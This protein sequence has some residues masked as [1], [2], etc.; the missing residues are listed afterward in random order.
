MD[1]LV[2]LVRS[3]FLFVFS[4]RADGYQYGSQQLCHSRMECLSIQRRSKGYYQYYQCREKMSQ[5]KNCKSCVW[6][7]E[8]LKVTCPKYCNNYPQDADRKQC[9]ES[10]RKTEGCYSSYCFNKCPKACPDYC[11]VKNE[12]T[13]ESCESS[14]RSSFTKCRDKVCIS[15][16]CSKLPSTNSVMKKLRNF[17]SL[18]PTASKSSLLSTTSKPPVAQVDQSKTISKSVI[19]PPSV[20]PTLSSSK[21]ESKSTQEASA[22]PRK[23]QS[24]RVSMSYRVFPFSRLW[25]G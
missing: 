7:C 23:E 20:L 5:S 6:K 3:L 22:E 2:L 19:I 24:L 10:M 8:Y 15:K 9:I 14:L 12:K 18:Q 16:Y 4:I 11:K 17:G 21:L 13:A 25:F 1:G